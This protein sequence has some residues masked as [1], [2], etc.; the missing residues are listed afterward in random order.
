M[1]DLDGLRRRLQE[2]APVVVAFSGGA[3]SAF[4]A[5]VAHDTLGGDRARAVTAVSPSLAPE[6]EA[7]CRELAGEWGLRWEAVETDELANALYVAN[8]ADRCYHCKS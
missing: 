1:A 5:W 8:G 7:E 3:D 2:L 6:E 4:L